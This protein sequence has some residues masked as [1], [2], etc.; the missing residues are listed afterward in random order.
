MKAVK[1]QLKNDSSSNVRPINIDAAMREDEQIILGT[2]S[3]TT[4]KIEGSGEGEIP[5]SANI[6]RKKEKK[7]KRSKTA[8]NNRVEPATVETRPYKSA[9]NVKIEQEEPCSSPDPLEPWSTKNI[10]DMNTILAW[11]REEDSI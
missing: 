5:E 7:K 9:S 10:T 2:I 4:L 8:K 3:E 1:E 11:E 6:N